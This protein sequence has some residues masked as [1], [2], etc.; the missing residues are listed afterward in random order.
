MLK[1]V[2][3][4][5]RGEIA[6]RIIRA[7]RD[8]GIESVAI[9][10]EADKESLHVLTADKAICVGPAP[11]GRSYLDIPNII[12]AAL[13][14]GC[15]AL[16]PGYGFLAENSQFAEICEENDI[17]FIGP[18]S[19]QIDLMGDKARAIKAAI[20]AN[21]PVVPGSNGVLP[22]FEKALEMAE[23]ISYPVLLKASAGGGGKGMRI[24]WEP[25]Q[26]EAAWN[27]ASNEAGAAFANSDLYMEKYIVRSRHVEVQILGDGHGSAAVIGERDCTVQ[28]RHQKLL[29]ETPSPVIDK[30][31]REYL[32]SSSRS[33]AENI[34]YK[35]AG[36]VEYIFDMDNPGKFYFIEMNTRLQVEH[37]VT[38]MV[39]GIDLVAEQLRIAADRGFSFDP[40]N[41]IFS[42]CSIECRINAEDP[43]NNFMPSAG[44]I[45][46]L[47]LPGGAW[48]RVDTHVYAG[49]TIPPF[50]DSLI[51]KV[52]V[53]GKDRETAIKRM[54]RALKEFHIK[55]IKSTSEFHLRVLS[56]KA[57]VGGNFSTD[58]IEKEL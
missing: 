18:A 54:K 8:L 43:D 14:T 46:S 4:A 27:A 1:R 45:D 26:M 15:D 33:L 23:Q 13:V 32:F 25:N 6:L 30:E 58:F 55:G 22:S 10:S 12:S 21:V 2:L 44:K 28:R 57:F 51:A 39:T 31:T 11:A 48:T 36:T 3:V 16:H 50:Y 29:E 49:Y 20:K 7:C 24:V 41:V 52:I 37:P 42:G 17:I 9:Y 34:N 19:D 35:G 56:N 5:N 47:I 53:W 38:E 40:E